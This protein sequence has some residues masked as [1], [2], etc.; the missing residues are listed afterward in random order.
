M[1]WRKLSIMF[2]PLKVSYHL[3]VLSFY[4]IVNDRAILC[5]QKVIIMSSK[6]V[7]SFI[8][9]F[10]FRVCIFLKRYANVRTFTARQLVSLQINP[11]LHEYSR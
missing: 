4:L 5:I 1:E 8:W 7:M 3:F 6:M 2:Y 10:L 11:F 9:P